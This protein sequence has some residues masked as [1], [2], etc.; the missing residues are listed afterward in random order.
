M[1]N[2]TI[3][4]S[5]YMKAPVHTIG[6][7]ESL[8]TAYRRLQEL[9]ISSLAVTDAGAALVGVISRTDL[10]RVGRYEAGARTYADLLTF[11][12]DAVESVMTRDVLTVGV[13]DTVEQACQLMTRRWVHRVFTVDDSGALVGVFSTRDVMQAIGEKR[14][15][16]PIADFM[17]RPL[18]TIRAAE[19]ISLAAERLE[20]ARVSG[21]VVVDDEWPVGVFTQTDAL[22]SRDRRR[23][24]PVE[25]V[26][27]AAI[28][29]M[30]DD[31]RLF[32]AAQQG[33]A[34]RVRRIISCRKRDMIGILSGLDFA[35]AV[36]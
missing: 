3:P 30:P 16:K 35:R 26:M 8:D 25:E 22:R 10:L 20:K 11:P 34:M 15:N 36:L 33:L 18:F 32:R 4:V 6:A 23:D 29:C 28:V 1:S 13:D 17:S 24:T 27:D 21:L 19:P 31:T 5:L 2:F 9:S 7:N 14:V 12:P